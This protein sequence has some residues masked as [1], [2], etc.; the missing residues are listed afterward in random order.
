MGSVPLDPAGL[1]HATKLFDD[2]YEKI[3]RVKPYGG[4]KLKGGGIARGPMGPPKKK[5]EATDG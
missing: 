4:M 2:T 5:D 3:P 1:G